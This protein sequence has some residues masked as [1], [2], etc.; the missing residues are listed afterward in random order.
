VQSQGL[1]P[2][3]HEDEE[4]RNFVRM[5]D[6]LA[7]VPLQR[8]DDAKAILQNNTPPMLADLLA[9]FDTTY[10]YGSGPLCAVRQAAANAQQ[11]PIVRMVRV[12]PTFPRIIW[13]VHEATMQGTDRTNNKYE[14]WNNGFT[15]LVGQHHPPI[16]RAIEALRLDAALS[17][18]AIL[19]DQQGHR[20]SFHKAT[21]QFRQH[22]N[23][24]QVLCERLTH[25]E[26]DL[27]NFL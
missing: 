20:I 19:Q 27:P 17:V 22:E 15:Q 18:K 5:M 13:N 14:G 26:I 16:F 23:Q 7:L 12:A 11:V 1:V 6:A 9:Y 21:H 10:M 25:N 4:V 8:I 3:Y 24:L 2:L